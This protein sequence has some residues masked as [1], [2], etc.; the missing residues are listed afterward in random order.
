M[1]N[2][3][4]LGWWSWKVRNLKGA[5]KKREEIAVMEGV[6]KGGYNCFWKCFSLKNVSQQYFIIIFKKLFLTWAHQNN[7]KTPK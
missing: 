3:R 5:G 1:A 7:L 4:S 6:W 2:L